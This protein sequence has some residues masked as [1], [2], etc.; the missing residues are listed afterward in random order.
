[1]GKIGV[2]FLIYFFLEVLTTIEIGSYLGGVG[3]FLEIVFSALFGIFLL[4]NFNSSLKENL[5]SISRMENSPDRVLTS[6]IFSLIGAIL[7]IIPG[8]LSDI[9]GVLMQFNI[10]ALIF[11]K[12]IAKSIINL[13]QKR[14]YHNEY[15]YKR[16]KTKT[17]DIIDVKISE[18]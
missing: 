5:D 9:I 2:I 4:F 14:S 8:I 18:S 10:I 3:T 12:I 13:N 7:L 6:T 17:E 15:K 1:M 11:G 16:N